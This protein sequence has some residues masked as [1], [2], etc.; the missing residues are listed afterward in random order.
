MGPS[1][2]RSCRCKDVI[3]LPFPLWEKKTR[4]GLCNDALWSGSCYMHSYSL[5]QVQHM[6]IA[7]SLFLSLSLHSLLF[8]PWLS[9]QAKAITNCRYVARHSAMGRPCRERL[10]VSNIKTHPQSHPQQTLYSQPPRP[11]L[12][13]PQV[14]CGAYPRT[15]QGPCKAACTPSTRVAGATEAPHNHR[16]LDP[17]PLLAAGMTASLIHDARCPRPECPLPILLTAIWLGCC[18]GLHIKVVDLQTV[19]RVW[20][21]IHGHV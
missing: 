5:F 13:S 18:S 9:E 2:S 4:D 21:L 7:F 16:H 19:R 8:Y 6:C 15:P 12:R 10:S 11:V 1:R 17:G 3:T 14:N 20:W